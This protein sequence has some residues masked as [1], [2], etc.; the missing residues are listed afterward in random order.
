LQKKI[1][2]PGFLATGLCIFG[3]NAYVNNSYLVTPF[4]NA[5]GGSKGAF[6]FYHSQ[7]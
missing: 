4:K 7:L 3:D 5:K 2:K 1:E 6:N